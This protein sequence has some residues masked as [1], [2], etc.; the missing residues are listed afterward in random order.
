MKIFRIIVGLSLLLLGAACSS[1][2]QDDLFDKSPSE[3]LEEYRAQYIE[4]L[5]S[6]EDGWV[7]QYFARNV[8]K[9]GGVNYFLSFK[10]GYVT[11]S[12]G[13]RSQ[14][15]MYTVL[16]RAGSVLSF[17]DD[18]KI[19]L[20]IANQRAVDPMGFD[21][22]VDFE[23]LILSA[24]DDE[25]VL[26]GLRSGQ[27]S[28]LVKLTSKDYEEKLTEVESFFESPLWLATDSFKSCYFSA[29][30][31]FNFISSGNDKIKKQSF[32][33][34][35]KGIKFY[36][37]ITVNGAEISEF[38]FE[39][40]T[41]LLKNKEGNIVIKMK[42]L[43]LDF[44][45]QEWRMKTFFEEEGETPEVAKVFKENFLNAYDAIEKK[46]GENL[47]WFTYLG[48]RMEA[49]GINF[50]AFYENWTKIY[51]I[52][53]KVKFNLI[54]DNGNFFVEIKNKTEGLNWKYYHY[55]KLD[56]IVDLLIE[57]STY[58]IEILEKNKKV[59]LISTK[60]PEIWFILNR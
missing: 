31:V 49:T 22:D 10:D 35:D 59:K 42:E 25:I 39:K 50:E 21:V 26:K 19:L 8:K 37:P 53:C 38:I 34:T 46:Y 11:A 17:N 29:G 7:F 2:E 58:K 54:D 45:V 12:K 5:E 33:C 52:E 48:Y 55:L 9:Y 56:P 41:S 1:I 44:N 60:N 36:E 24:K 28:R 32:V 14:T 57:N 16:N 40:E 43:P 6:A 18:N 15:S 3:R 4:K 30:R 20:E 23:F 27:I 47:S 51:K 13:G